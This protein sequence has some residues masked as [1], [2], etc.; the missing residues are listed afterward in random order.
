MVISR[1][2]D[3]PKVISSNPLVDWKKLT[4]CYYV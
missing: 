1:V 2:T 4:V 3:P